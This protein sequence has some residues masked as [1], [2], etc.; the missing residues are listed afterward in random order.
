[1]TLVLGIGNRTRGDD[2]AGPCVAEHVAALGLPGVEVIV[3]REPLA[4]V[5]ILDSHDVVV[6]IDAVSAQGDPGRVHVWPIDSLPAGRAGPPIGSH[7]L[8]VRDAVELARALGSLPARL[9]VVGIEAET[10]E[11]GAPLSRP[12][13]D[14]LGDAVQAVREALVAAGPTG[15]TQPRSSTVGG[16][17]CRTLRGPA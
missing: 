2:G 12:V 4:L 14:H 13:R 6:I 16:Q 15:T 5:E 17:D 11:V 7:A 3:E 1:M 8:G 10:F 9:T